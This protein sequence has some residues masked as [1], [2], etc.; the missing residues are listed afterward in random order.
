MGGGASP[1]L[2]LPFLKEGWHTQS[3]ISPYFFQFYVLYIYIYIYIFF[4]FFFFGGS[5]NQQFQVDL[6]VKGNGK[7]KL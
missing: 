6:G 3:W 1:N 5:K 4:F 7:K 2:P